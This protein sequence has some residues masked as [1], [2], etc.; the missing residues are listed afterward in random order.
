[1]MTTFELFLTYC[2][3]KYIDAYNSYRRSTL[4]FENEKLTI[5][6]SQYIH[7]YPYLA[8]LQI[9]IIDAIVEGS[10]IKKYAQLSKKTLKKIKEL[11]KKN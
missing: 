3:P 7:A 11:L 6:G 10:G 8:R 5:L 2:C 1:M 9:Y 4:K